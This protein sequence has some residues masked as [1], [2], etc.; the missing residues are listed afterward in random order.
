M[1]IEVVRF[2][3]LNQTFQQIALAVDITYRTMGVQLGF[4]TSTAS[5]AFGQQCQ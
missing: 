4:P 5:A 2:A 3:E 1:G